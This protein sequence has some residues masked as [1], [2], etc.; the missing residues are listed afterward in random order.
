[1]TGDATP[2][3]AHTGE[4]LQLIVHGARGS[5]S[6]AGP[7][8]IETGGNTTCYSVALDDGSMLI[9]D[10]GTGLR[11]L[12]HSLGDPGPNEYHVLLTHYHWDH[13]QGIPF[14]TPL[15]TAGTKFTFYGHTWHGKA[16][17]E[18]LNSAIRPP[19][20]PVS[21]QD[22]PADLDFVTLTDEPLRLGNITITSAPLHH[23]QGVTAYR[24]QNG[25]RSIVV[26]TDHEAGDPD[27][28][29]TLDLLAQGTDVLLHDGQYTPEEYEARYR[30]W[31]HST[32]RQAAAAAIRAG[33]GRLV[34][35]SHD[36]ERSD[37]ALAALIT[38]ARAVF[39]A[40]EAGHE[41]MIL[42]L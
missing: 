27:A 15:Y 1:M 29:A 2:E 37:D 20:F 5:M 21:L 18:V 35:V 12:Q 16:P 22:S 39:P 6:A 8:L 31:G 30:G 9:V 3:R 33:A 42:P 14:F 7:H 41:G 40:T 24:L 38:Q 10:C 25:S 11:R 4:A 34:I 26:A 19:W 28:D 23:P 36:P 17:G 13:I 32:W